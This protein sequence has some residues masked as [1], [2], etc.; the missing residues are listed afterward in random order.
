L[1]GELRQLDGNLV[2]PLRLGIIE[3]NQLSIG[4]RPFA[5]EGCGSLC[6]SAAHRCKA[7]PKND[8]RSR[9]MMR[10]CRKPSKGSTKTAK[11]PA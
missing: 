10:P 9:L 3:T 8:P 7:M 5:I 1:T 6:L 11:S 2:G 4:D